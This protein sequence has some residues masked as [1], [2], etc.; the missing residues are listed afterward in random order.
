MP[1]GQDYTFAMNF[2]YDSWNRIKNMTY[3]DG[4]E[5]SYNYNDA[6]QLITMTGAKGSQNFEY[7]NEIIY[8]RYGSRKHISYGNG[9]YSDYSYNNLNQQLTNLKSYDGNNNLMQDLTY[10]YDNISNITSIQNTAGALSNGLG[11]NYSYSYSYDNLYRL[12]SS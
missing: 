9:T 11:G 5:V 6:G 10:T 2:K 12:T 4:E 8:N 3:P 1:G 7:V